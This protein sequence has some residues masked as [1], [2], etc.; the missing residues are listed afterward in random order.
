MIGPLLR[1]FGSTIDRR[2]K[3]QLLPRSGTERLGGAAVFRW[4]ARGL[5]LRASRMWLRHRK[6][7]PG[8]YR[9]GSI[10]RTGFEPVA[11]TLKG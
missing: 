9:M 8:G 10:G 7:P 5:R 2:T 11:F 1:F 4:L 3:G 6:S